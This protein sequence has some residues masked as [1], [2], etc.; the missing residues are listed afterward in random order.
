M[1]KTFRKAMDLLLSLGGTL[2]ALYVGGYWLLIRP[3]QNLYA[4][5]ME[6]AIT[7]NLLLNSFIRIFV[8]AT[9]FGSIWCIFDIL[10]GFFRDD[11]EEN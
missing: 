8:S 3:L 2:L 1:K 11:E 7:W 10:A 4:G 5:Y 9:V 6:H